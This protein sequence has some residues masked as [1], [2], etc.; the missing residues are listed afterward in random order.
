MVL[1][2]WSW[3]C[4]K[5]RGSCERGWRDKKK[6]GLFGWNKQNTSQRHCQVSCLCWTALFSCLTAFT[7][8]STGDVTRADNHSYRQRSRS[9]RLM[10]V[11]GRNLKLL[12]GCTLDCQC[13]LAPGNHEFHRHSLPGGLRHV[14]VDRERSAFVIVSR[15]GGSMYIRGEFNSFNTRT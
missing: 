11:M 5:R 13:A 1:R 7:E 2:G 15:C 10:V 6:G 4:C 12:S 9:V 8:L 3:R 14:A